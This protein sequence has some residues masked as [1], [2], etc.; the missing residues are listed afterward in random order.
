MATLLY[1]ETSPR[2]ADSASSQ[3]AA[4]FVETYT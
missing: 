1:I 4:T 3:I 2:K